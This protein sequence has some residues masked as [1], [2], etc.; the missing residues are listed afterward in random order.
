MWACLVEFAKI[1]PIITALVAAGG[2]SVAI[3]Q[4]RSNQKNQRE[5]TAK[6]VFREYLRLAFEHSDLAEPDYQKLRAQPDKYKKYSWFVAHLLW[7]CEE[8]LRYEK[9]EIWKENL[10]RNVD[11][12][13]EYFINDSEFNEKD[14]RLYDS[15]VQEL[16]QNAMARGRNGGVRQELA[17]GVRV[18]ASED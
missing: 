9:G 12:H 6:S 7:A 11:Y 8:I 4:L 16:V 3:G 17:A 1:A 15:S 2:V 13:R 5:S 14:F 18:K 10:Q